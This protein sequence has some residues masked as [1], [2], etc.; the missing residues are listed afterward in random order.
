MIGFSVEPGER[1]AVTMSAAQ[2]GQL[3]AAWPIQ[4]AMRPSGRTISDAQPPAAGGHALKGCLQP[5]PLQLLLQHLPPRLLQQQRV[6]F[7]LA[8][9]IEQQGGADLQLA[10]GFVLARH[11]LVDQTAHLGDGAE[12]AAAQLREV[13]RL[14]Q[15]RL[16]LVH[17][18]QA[19]AV[20]V[21]Q[22]LKGVAL[23]G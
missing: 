7:V 20:Q 14:L 9:H 18:Q 16:E 4:A 23:G 11:A 2:P 17:R 12:A 13:H 22:L 8:E 19:V 6:G 1:Q 10:A 21:E 15:I 5:R 3:V